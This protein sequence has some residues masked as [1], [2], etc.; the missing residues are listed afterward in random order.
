MAWHEPVDASGKAPIHKA[1]ATKKKLSTVTRKPIQKASS[2]NTYY[3]ASPS[4]KLR[5]KTF[6]PAGYYEAIKD[7]GCPEH[8]SFGFILSKI[9]E[10]AF[11][12]SLAGCLMAMK[13]SE[14][15]SKIDIYITHEEPDVDISDCSMDFGVL[16][17]VRYRRN[18]N[19]EYFGTYTLSKEFLKQIRV[20][21]GEGREESEFG[22]TDIEGVSIDETGLECLKRHL[23][24]S[25]EHGN[26]I[27][28]IPDDKY[29][30]C[31]AKG[32]GMSLSQYKKWSKNMD[33]M[34]DYYGG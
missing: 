8:R 27:E 1:V 18:V 26:S 34:V 32:M 22:E 7:S 31:Q 19:V 6:K 9:P 21:Y 2:Q 33:E 13:D 17:E 11:S 20:C 4:T 10:T 15:D 24:Y 23:I 28:K 5:L 16:E 30:A 12:K 3:H 14:Q 25:L 29:D